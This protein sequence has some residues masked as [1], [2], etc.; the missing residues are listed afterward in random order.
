MT[1]CDNCKNL[2]YETKWSGFPSDP[3]YP[4]VYCSKGHWSGYGFSENGGDDPWINCKD[5]ELKEKFI[6][7][8]LKWTHKNDNCFTLWRSKSSGY[9]WFK[10]WAGLYDKPVSDEHI[11]SVPVEAI[12]DQWVLIEY[13]GYVWRGLPNTESV[14]EILGIKKKDLMRNNPSPGCPDFVIGGDVFIL[15]DDFRMTLL[16]MIK[17][18]VIIDDRLKVK[19]LLLSRKILPTKSEFLSE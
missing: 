12:K 16:G 1:I 11:V 13:D 10:S 2:C 9:C 19:Q 7:V 17:N 5:F 3:I 14:R 4:E 8:S 6:Y 18:S 15:D